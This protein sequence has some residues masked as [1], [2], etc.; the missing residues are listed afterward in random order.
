MDN[1]KQKV[2]DLEEAC[3]KIRAFCVYRERSQTEVRE[4]LYTYGLISEVRE[5]LLMELIQD[6]YLNE[7]RFA[8]AFVRGKFNI[9]KWGRLK[10]KKE[11]Y[12]H[13]LSDYVLRKAFAEIDEQDYQKTLEELLA[14]K[15]RETQAA[16]DFQRKGKVARYMINKGFEPD[17]VWE[18]LTSI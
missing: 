4:K 18:C 7:E 8:R 17:L 2:Y 5:Q 10:I 3:E 1:K 9:K 12:K 14:K 15:M 6:N 13:Q 11:L 16:N